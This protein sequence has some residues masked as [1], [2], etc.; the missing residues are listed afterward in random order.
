M[1]GGTGRRKV[2]NRVETLSVADIRRLRNKVT[3]IRDRCLILLGFECACRVNEVMEFTVSGINWDLKTISKWDIK[4]KEWRQIG[5]SD[6]LMTDL[7]LYIDSFRLKDRLF[8]IGWKR[9]SEILSDACM[10]IGVQGHISWHV[11]RRT[12]CSLGEDMGY[13]MKDVMYITGDTE[14][15]VARYYKKVSA[16]DLGRKANKFYQD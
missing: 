1:S 10:S 2:E 14:R 12:L 3:N 7:R 15:T 11:L 16:A 9:C 6:T 4:K 13:S 5:L 8:D